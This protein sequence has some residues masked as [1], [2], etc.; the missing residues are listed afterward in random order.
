MTYARLGRGSFQTL[1]HRAQI[2]TQ[3]CNEFCCS[4]YPGL[5]QN[6]VLI[7]LLAKP[8]GNGSCKERLFKEADV[9]PSSPTHSLLQA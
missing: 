3:L 8:D 5:T 7:L 1:A 2:C 9:E 4:F 6:R